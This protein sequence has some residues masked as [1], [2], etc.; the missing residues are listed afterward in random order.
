[1]KNSEQKELNQDPPVQEGIPDCFRVRYRSEA[2]DIDFLVK[3]Y[4]ADVFLGVAQISDG[5]ASADLIRQRAK[6]LLPAFFPRLY[7]VAEV[8]L[9]RLGLTGKIEVYLDDRSNPSVEPLA[10]FEEDEAGQKT[11]LFCLSPMDVERFEDDELAFFFG[12]KLAGSLWRIDHYSKLEKEP[13]EDEP[14]DEEKSVLP[15]MGQD[16]Y[17]RWVAKRQLSMDRVGAM[18]AGGFEPAARALLKR[19][20]PVSGRNIAI[21]CEDEVYMAAES[22]TEGGK[23]SCRSIS[24]RLTALRLFC[25]EWFSSACTPVSLERADAALDELF[26]KGRRYPSDKD[27]EM[28][29]FLIADI[30]FEML[31]QGGIPSDRE[32]RF[33]LGKV[34]EYTEDPF[35]VVGVSPV[36]RNRRIRKCL[37]IV[38]GREDIGYF[39]DAL[40]STIDL[41]LLAGPKSESRLDFVRKFVRRLKSVDEYDLV[42]VE[43]AITRERTLSDAEFTIDPLMDELVEDVK[44]MWD[45]RPCKSTRMSLV[46]RFDNATEQ[47]SALDFLRYSGDRETESLL[48]QVYHVESYLASCRE[49]C[50]ADESS[51]AEELYEGLELTEEVSP[52]VVGIVR[53][54]LERLRYQEPLDVYCKRSDELNASA[55]REMVG[56][57]PRG[58]IQINSAA[59]ESLDDDELAY[60]IGHEMGHLIFKTAEMGFL[61]LDE[62]EDS[63]KNTL[64]IMGDMKLRKWHQMMEMSADR[65]GLWASQNLEASLR[66]LIKLSYGIS[67]K[68]LSEKAVDALLKQLET[69]K[70][71]HVIGGADL[72]DHPLA[73]LRLKA[74]QLFGEACESVHYDEELLK[75][76]GKLSSVDAK[77]SH[78]LHWLR[79]YPRTAE[80][81]AAMQ[82]FATAAVNIVESDGRL[83]EREIS[84][85]LKIL[86]CHF[87]EAPLDEL[88]VN[89]QDR[90]V[91]LKAAAETLAVFKNDELK[92][93]VLVG[94]IQVALADGSISSGEQT[95][96]ESI[97][98][99]IGCSAPAFLQ[100]EKDV[101]QQS[102]FP[103]DFLM[104][105]EVK[106]VRQLM[107]EM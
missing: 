72:L 23:L 13:V 61:T 10:T 48:R 16:V 74:L 12:E 80:S 63:C 81:L 31:T 49:L 71:N 21:P 76:S 15:G 90:N 20:F 8:T 73:H 1:M 95:Y 37:K 58:T 77:I 46:G 85:I 104:E 35:A 65:M 14:T 92:R 53:K 4:Q 43:R 87:T 79:R 27:R 96:L 78:Y 86:V 83:E 52:R 106:K 69:I 3:K 2:E 70:D 18:A 39:T 94:L 19:H 6:P 17:R 50:A 98:K 44:L 68:N 24:F 41:A 57:T 100:L 59:L 101:V 88:V 102:N 54:V 7:H 5:F 105:D 25:R 97:A 67:S 38:E 107:A 64:P 26:A 62:D 33:L 60:V 75:K 42:A 34:L 40:Y 32:I 103:V 51:R 93:G 28:A 82:V 55:S 47:S 91:R 29:M 84:E 56:G 9:E 66:A 36:E 30:G 11:F 45:G 99:R 89:R 22:L